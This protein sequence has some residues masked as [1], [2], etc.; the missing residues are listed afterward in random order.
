MRHIINHELA[1]WFYLTK[2]YKMWCYFA[3]L[4]LLILSKN[5]MIYLKR[6]RNSRNLET[7]V[8]FLYLKYFCNTVDI[9]SLF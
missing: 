8:V 6:K 3:P 4:T 7:D 5:I 2:N 9:V 1:R